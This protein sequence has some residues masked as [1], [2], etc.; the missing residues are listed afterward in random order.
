M[1]RIYSTEGI[2]LAKR[3]AGEAGSS[4]TLLTRELGLVYATAISARAA[5]SKL[6]YGIEPLMHGRFSLVHGKSGWRLT[7]ALPERRLLSM[8]PSARAATGR[9]ARLLVRLIR[10]EEPAP[11]LF[12]QVVNGFALLGNVSTKEEVESVECVLVLRVLFE[13]GYLPRTDLL[14]PFVE[15]GLSLGLAAEAMHSRSLLVR[16]INDSLQASGL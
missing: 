4:C 2:V 12:A 16:A 3:G 5:R 8:F 6:K 9:I 13:L 14:A 7:A 10:G 1:Y 15:R 11:V